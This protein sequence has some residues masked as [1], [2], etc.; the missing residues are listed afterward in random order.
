L[1]VGGRV[2]GRVGVRAQP[3]LGDLVV[4][5]RS[6]VIQY[7]FVK[8]T[9]TAVEHRHSPRPP[10]A[11]LL[12]ADD[13]LQ[14]LEEEGAR[15]WEALLQR[16]SHL[17]RGARPSAPDVLHDP[18]DPAQLVAHP[19]D[20]DRQ[21]GL[22]RVF[23]GPIASSHALLK[24]PKKRDLLRDTFGV[25]AVEMEAS[26]I[27]DA[28]WLHE[29]GYFVV[30][31]TC[32]YCDAHK[33]DAWQT[34]AAVIAAAY[35][36]ALLGCMRTPVLTFPL[37]AQRHGAASHAPAPAQPVPPTM[38]VAPSSP[39]STGSAP[40]VAPAMPV[41]IQ[42]DVVYLFAPGDEAHRALLARHLAPAL[43]RL[44]LRD[45]HVG[46][47][48]LGADPAQAVDSALRSARVVL[49]LISPDYLV[50][51]GCRTAERTALSLV[52]A[53]LRV[54]PVSLRPIADWS[55]EPFGR[56]AHVPRGNTGKPV[57]KWSSADEAWVDVVTSVGAVLSS[58]AKAHGAG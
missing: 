36:R 57:V 39:V 6:G 2:D 28:T 48:P 13:A 37:P 11:R 58:V 1:R 50:E 55:N 35:A 25:K 43:R 21:E 4:S 19:A 9:E 5:N 54:V 38:P 30:R 10:G 23:R 16:A 12:E 22:P 32:D 8:E 56:L 53:G 44:Q 14:L 33:S 18:D 15:P 3:R 40:A 7:D 51:D 27:A 45:W 41:S 31:G 34:Y 52:A 24:N 17:S 26:G 29:K 20:P 49:L 46:N 42:A 47:T